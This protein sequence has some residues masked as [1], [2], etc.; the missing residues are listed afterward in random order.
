M[1]PET[2]TSRASL[3][4]H[5][6][7]TLRQGDGDHRGHHHVRAFR[8]GGQRR[9][10]DPRAH[11]R[12]TIP[13]GRRDGSG[14][15]PGVGALPGGSRRPGA[16]PTE[17]QL[18]SRP[19]R[20][21]HRRLC[22]RKKTIG[23]RRARPCGMGR[24]HA[25]QAGPGPFRGR[26]TPRGSAGPG[27]RVLR[28]CRRR[29]AELRE[30][31]GARQARGG[32]ACGHRPRRGRDDDQ[33]GDRRPQAAEPDDHGRDLD[34]RRLVRRRPVPDAGDVDA[35]A[36]SS[37]CRQPG[38]FPRRFRRRPGRAARRRDWPARPVLRCHERR[39]AQS[40]TSSCAASPTPSRSR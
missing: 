8:G 18:P 10:A 40:A 4:R 23:Q 21:V 19:Q 32:T 38:D 39:P 20:P 29:S 1:E 34:R 36:A 27:R 5:L 26:S 17:Q 33:T 35:A 14:R 28:R 7:L 15:C 12:R 25:R 3:K 22:R 2:K 13:F 6:R 30:R 9:A 24:L 11:R 37:V 31:S 16:F